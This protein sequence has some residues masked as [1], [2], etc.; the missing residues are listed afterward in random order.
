M[1]FTPLAHPRSLLVGHLRVLDAVR[2]HLR[3]LVAVVGFLPHKP[4]RDL[5]RRATRRDWDDLMPGW[6]ARTGSGEATAE[7]RTLAF[8]DYLLPADGDPM[9]VGVVACPVF[10]PEEGDAEGEAL[11]AWALFVLD[12]RPGRREGDERRRRAILDLLLERRNEF[13][14]QLG[15][16]GGVE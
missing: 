11:A 4:P 1:P 2:A 8:E 12:Q 13:V 14:V 16:H 5:E 3:Q 15:P 6:S 9:W 10:T 7:P